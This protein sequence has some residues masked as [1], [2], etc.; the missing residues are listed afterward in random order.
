M[1]IFILQM[2]KQNLE[3]ITHYD[4]VSELSFEQ[5]GIDTLPF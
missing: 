4:T 3:R 5:I 2:R 1:I